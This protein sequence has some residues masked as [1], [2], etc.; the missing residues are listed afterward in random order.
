[1]CATVLK[2]PIIFAHRGAN[3]FAPENSIPA[4]ENAIDMGCDGIE[5]D[6]RLCASGEV[7]VFHD[8]STAR[9]T[10]HRGSIHRMTF[11]EIKQLILGNIDSNM[12]KIGKSLK[13]L[14]CPADFWKK[15]SSGGLFGNR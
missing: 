3:S 9:M 2:L 12:K 6:V 4:F 8:R 10:G 11:S 14:L 13:G 7:V 15:L 1:M 5:L